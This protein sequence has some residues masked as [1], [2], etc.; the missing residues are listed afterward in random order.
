MNKLSKTLI[1]ASVAVAAVGSVALGAVAANAAE[2]S[3]PATSDKAAVSTQHGS[4]DSVPATP[5]A[6]SDE[7]PNIVYQDDQIAVSGAPGVTVDDYKAA[8]DSAH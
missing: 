7:K 8:T 5:G 4:A 2:T 6:P 1:G 3:A